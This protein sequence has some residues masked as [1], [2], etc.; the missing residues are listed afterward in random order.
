M[1]RTIY[2]LEKLCHKIK[3]LIF[4]CKNSLLCHELTKIFKMY[5]MILELSK[6]KNPDTKDLI[7]LFNVARTERLKYCDYNEQFII[8]LKKED[9][10]DEYLDLRR[11]IYKCEIT[12]FKSY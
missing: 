1:N 5:N 11:C 3:S 6:N 8:C 2:S 4:R 9:F 10:I 12:A 7:K